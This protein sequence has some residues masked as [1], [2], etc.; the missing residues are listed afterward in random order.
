MS[1]IGNRLLQVPSTV[2]VNVKANEVILSGN[3]QTL[4]VAFPSGIISVKFENQTLK[5][6]RAN[7]EKQSRMYHGTVNA[8]LNNAIVGLTT[9]WKKELD[10]KG[11]GFKAKVEANKLNLGLGF[12]HPIILDIPKD[13][14][15]TTP[16]PTEISIQG[17][18]KA[19]VGAFAAT[20]RGYRPPEPYKGKGVMYKNEH[21]I[22]KAGK[23][24]DKKK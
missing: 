1:R 15:I 17:A 11:V 8:N 5:V 3:N 10:I 14:N 24:A 12:S 9:G 13:L 18:D 22:R 16:S 21:I 19:A 7:D 2:S 23:T 4:T 6:T 20:I